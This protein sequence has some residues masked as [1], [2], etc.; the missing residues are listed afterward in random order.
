MFIS[1]SMAILAI[2]WILISIFFFFLELLSVGLFFFGSI[3]IGGIVGLIMLLIGLGF[4]AQSGF[5]I[6]SMIISFLILRKITKSVSKDTFHKSNIYMLIGKKGIVHTTIEANSKGWVYIN[7]E[8]WA[9]R[10][11]QGQEIE[12]NSEIIV[13]S[14]KGSHLIVEEII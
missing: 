13:I 14:T 12:Q 7:G 5:F 4:L 9:A 10:S 6:L 3:A 2:F 8:I 1:I 11:S